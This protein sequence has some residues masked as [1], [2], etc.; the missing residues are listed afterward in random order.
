MTGKK[1][2]NFVMILLL[3]FAFVL[4]G[5]VI[6]L[7]LFGES[8]IAADSGAGDS[9]SVAAASD[10]DMLPNGSVYY[11]SD[12][13][14]INNFRSGSITTDVSS[15]V[16]NNSATHGTASNPFVIN[17]AAQWV[18]FANSAESQIATNVF[19]LGKDIT[20]NNNF[21][22]VLQ[23]KARFYGRNFALINVVYN[24]NATSAT[25]TTGVFCTATSTVVTDLSVDNANLSGVGYSG[26]GIIGLSDKSSVL[27]CHFRGTI[28][29]T[30]DV[31]GTATAGIVGRASGD[32]EVYIYR[33]SVFMKFNTTISSKWGD[34]CG[35]MLGSVVEKVK[36]RIYDCLAINNV[37]MVGNASGDGW[38]AGI[39]SYGGYNG[40]NKTGAIPGDQKVDS[41]VAYTDFVS[42]VPAGRMD[43]P[44]SAISGW[45]NGTGN[46]S[47]T[48]NNTYTDGVITKS[49][50][51]KTMYPALAYSANGTATGEP[52][53]F[54][55]FT[56]GSNFNFFAD[57]GLYNF[58]P[59]N[60]GAL[61]AMDLLAAKGITSG[62]YWYGNT[63]PGGR[64]AMYAKA[65]ANLPQKIWLNRSLI[66][67]G[68][69]R[70]TDVSTT[71]GYTV[72][73]SPVRN[74]LVIKVKYVNL[75]KVSGVD[76][77]TV[78]VPNASD[79]DWHIVNHGDTLATP[80]E[81]AGHEY[82]GW[83]TDKT[84]NTAPITEV[85]DNF[86]GN[87]VLYA[88]WDIKG[89]HLDVQPKIT[90]ATSIE[91]LPDSKITI[92]GYA[93]ITG[94]ASNDISITY[95]WHK[96][97]ASDVVGTENKYEVST[98]AQT[99]KYSF[100]YLIYDATEPLW[101]HSG[102][103][104]DITATVTPGELSVRTGTFQIDSNTPAYVGKS[105]EL[106]NFSVQF[107][108]KA[109]QV[110]AGTAKWEAGIIKVDSGMNTV[111]IE[112]T[113]SNSSDAA[114]YESG[115]KYPVRFQSES[116]KLIFNLSQI[117]RTYEIDITYGQT[118]S[119]TRI[120]S[121]FNNAFAQYSQVA[122]DKALYD[123]LKTRSPFLDDGNN[124]NFVELNS[125]T[126]SFVDVTDSITINVDFR[127]VKYTIT[128]DPDNGDSTFTQ[129][130]SYNNYI[131]KPS[132]DPEKSDNGDDLIFDNWYITESDGSERAWDFDNDIVTGN[133]TL[134]AKYF[135]ANMQF[136]G[137]E[138]RVLKD[139]IA[140]NK[141]ASG[142]LKVTA[143]L[144]GTGMDGNP[145]YRDVDV[146]F[147]T[148]GLEYFYD[149]NSSALHF[150][151][152]TLKVEYTFRGVKQ[153]A[154]ISITV[155]KKEIVLDP[156]V[157]LNP[158]TF[159]Y[160]GNP[161]KITALNMATL[162]TEVK[163]VSYTYK[164]YDNPV[165]ETDVKEIGTYVVTADFEMRSD[166][167][168][169][170]SLETTLT[171]T[172]AGTVITVK[173]D[174]N[175]F[176]FNGDKQHPTATF[177]NENGDPVEL[178]PSD[179]EYTQDFEAIDA[180][181]YF[182]GI[183]LKTSAY[184]LSSNDPYVFTIKKAV[185]NTPTQTTAATYTG[186]SIFV[187][188]LLD[189]FND[190]L[191]EI[192]VNSDESGVAAKS[193]TA[194][195]TLKYP[196]S[197]EWQGTSSPTVTV[198]WRIDRA[199]LTAIW[200]S[201]EY[202]YKAGESVI[203]HI[204]RLSGLA[205]VDE[206]SV[207]YVN[208]FTYLGDTE[209]NAVGAYRVTAS[210]NYSSDWTNNYVLDGN[211]ELYYAVVP[212]L[213]MTVISIEWSVPEGGLIFDGT[214]KKPTYVIL[215]S[216]GNEI[217]GV[218]LTI[219]GDYDSAVW[220]GDYSLT[221][222]VAESSNY[223]IRKGAT[224]NYSI[225]KND[226]GEG[227]N[228]GLGNGGDGGNAVKDFFDKLI[229]SHFP[230]WQV[231]TMAVSGLL[232]LIFMIK[233]IQYGNRAKKVKKTG[234]KAYAALLPVFS[235]DVVALGLSNKIWS[236][237]A[238]SFMGLAVLMF[239]IALITRH[240]WKKAE[241]ARG[242]AVSGGSVENQQHSNEFKEIKEQL[243][244]MSSQQSANAGS[245]SSD[246]MAIIEAMRREM[247]DREERYRR[248]EEER[249]RNDEERHR[250]E[251]AALREEQA[252]RDDAMK[253]MLANMMGRP[254][255]EDGFAYATLDDTDMLVQRVIAGLLPAV[256]QM[257]PE[258]TA[259]L[260][261]PQE[262]NEE[263]LHIVEEQNAQMQ[264]MSDQM[265]EL[266]AQL[267]SMHEMADAV[268]IPDNSDDI[269]AMTDE[270]NA[271]R[272]QIANLSGQPVTVVAADNSEDMKAVTDEVNAL[273]AQVAK[274]S[275]SQYDMAILDDDDDDNFD[276]DDEEEWDSILDE[277]EDDS[278][279][280]SVIIEADGTVR[281]VSPN[282]RMRLKQ[283]S[284]K[285]REWYAAIKNLFCSQKGVTY[286]VCKRIEKIRYQG[287]VIAVIGIAKRS[288]KLWLALKPYEYDARRYHHKDVSDKPRFVDV[289]LYV[290]VG[291]D[292]ALIRAQE[293][294]LALFQ[295]Q[296]MEARKRYNDR[297]IQELIFTL[298]YNK[299][300]TKKGYKQLLCETIH[301]HDC[302]VLTNEMAEKCIEIKNVDYIDDSVI[303]MVKLDDID[304]KFQD[305][306]RVTLDRL[307]KV[308][309][310]SEECTGYTV[311]AGQRL[312]KPLIIVANDFTMEA[313]KMIALTGGRVIK[314]AQV[315]QQ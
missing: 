65:A 264:A 66:T 140:T 95:E 228:P 28:T 14:K 211:T 55:S 169:V 105:L 271:L 209:V 46:W 280:E 20:F 241:A 313:V 39:V 244:L 76:N 294:I 246:S 275:E 91:Y 257:M 178:D 87:Y 276:F 106:I 104:T 302:D 163:A 123:G 102:T 3:V 54:W 148:S 35:G 99:G 156:S 205:H 74:P 80:T 225:L 33:C 24:F 40:T 195:I 183:N 111:N 170:K 300:L 192:D 25:S 127:N 120:I 266:Q 314:L 293:L 188:D 274:L 179:F 51:K 174:T 149:N 121:E 59:A 147:G 218:Q 223:F 164:L 189:I 245:G 263:L 272:E 190:N 312:T 70:N 62:Y 115:V 41:C 306:N 265:S 278:F 125:Y 298:K 309:L 281:K 260:A 122:A 303:E 166:D 248:D 4:T 10:Y 26:G 78:I 85:P 297:D 60:K 131:L 9:A 231:I 173:W 17:T 239:V 289:P 152:T 2:L 154:T 114:N 93:A 158:A 18:T 57:S 139:L 31:D 68:Y 262:Q 124:A 232:A 23:L 144:Q 90:G 136:T 135:S 151:H 200:D 27:N 208:D 287:N 34:P 113:P 292:R 247:L 267:A 227:E 252:K 240:S 117:S 282:F 101:R 77:E 134:T 291:S 13:N 307:R 187:K 175:T 243:A 143:K 270:M 72:Y 157:K 168:F 204:V 210:L 162:P 19:V 107:I 238:F 116:L 193:Y 75:T 52:F 226:K 128:F 56:M 261:A 12:V 160:D 84:G 167:Y 182:I 137:L 229:A 249:R 36:T 73:N 71:S 1:R 296:A 42:T 234:V 96:D 180:D 171:I 255:G 29:K 141:I 215:D 217:T 159:V 132:P 224:Y 235:G 61:Y 133:M 138:V 53:K 268:I 146:A 130:C 212:R 69:M 153:T 44:A 191:M 181:T 11:Y 86:Y 118:Y 221:A 38:F 196:A 199:H 145:I 58:T 30:I 129:E 97:G 184:Q 194:I 119:N 256:Q 220:A 142:D 250:Q 49:G 103:T 206:T 213:G 21:Q 203:P 198:N 197:S 161:H 109:N 5:A 88:Y 155:Q 233:A 315:A 126:K 308:G 185:F 279:V 112:F 237:M 108:N 22:P 50:T 277:E 290:R 172:R 251:M 6:S 110:V 222:S 37:T 43:A 15:T 242:T 219:G 81:A 295:E 236:I 79:D 269:K 150:G 89:S 92:N 299:L 82:K 284:D 305:G 201:T 273:R 304:A 258:P 283:S 98:V 259:Y 230:L 254:Q 45:N 202:L 165:D 177:V 286:R 311:T 8:A 216:D 83:T 7:S 310:V 207:N 288:I 16:V 63:T 285:N 214:V 301:V 94:V 67:E 47:I 48:V 32:A 100:D 176:T 186:D 64:T 253:L